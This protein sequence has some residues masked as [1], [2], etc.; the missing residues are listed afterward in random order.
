MTLHDR[1]EYCLKLAEQADDLDTC[2]AYL[3]EAEGL[4]GRPLSELGF[5]HNE[6]YQLGLRDRAT[7]LKLEE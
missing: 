1:T 4:M 7:L 5:I 2:D 6:A 3:A